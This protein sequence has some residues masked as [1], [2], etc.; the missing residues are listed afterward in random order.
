MADNV[1][2]M[3]HRRHN[4]WAVLDPGGS[5]S[6]K[7]RPNGQLIRFRLQRQVDGAILDYAE[8]PPK[9]GGPRPAICERREITA[10]GQDPVA[11]VLAAPAAY[12]GVG[13]M[14]G[15][16]H[17]HSIDSEARADRIAVIVRAAGHGRHM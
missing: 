7:L 14:L 2:I 6:V 9:R 15:A 12:I 3:K 4:A 11:Y 13:T 5:D 16:G 1:Q 8:S 10:P 17:D